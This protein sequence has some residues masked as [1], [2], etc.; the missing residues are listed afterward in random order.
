MEGIGQITGGVAHD[1][2]NLLTI[3]IGNLDTLQRNLRAPG[4]RCTNGCS[5]RRTMPCGAHAGRNR[6][7]NGCSPFLGSSR[8]IPSPIDLGRLVSGMSDL[9]RRTLGE[10]IS[11]ETV[12]GGGLWSAS[13]DPNQLELAI[14]N[15]A[16][17]ARDAMPNGG[18]LTIETANVYLD[19]KYAASQAEVVPGQYVML[20]VTDSG[21]GMTPEVKAQGIRSFLHHEGYWPRHWSRS[22]SGIRLHQAVSRPCKNL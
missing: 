3:I 18:Q 2:N 15:L 5:D 4:I 21:T 14:L 16:I 20:A 6:S 8:L 12:L 22:V 10:Q 19:D 9:L 7:R 11:V 1:F 17:N 13:A